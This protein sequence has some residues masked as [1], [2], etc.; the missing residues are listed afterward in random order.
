M[1]AERGVP[2]LSR[3]AGLLAD[4]TRARFCLA[5]LDGRAW[6]AG[7]LARQAGVAASTTTEHL[8]AL[9]AGGLLEQVRQGRHRYV[10]L[11]SPEVAELVE[12]LAALAPGPEPV[13]RSLRARTR[14][15]RLAHARTCYDHLA[16]R[17]GVAVTEAMIGRGILADS[18]GLHLTPTGSAWVESV[19]LTVARGTRR[20][21]VRP[22]L[23]WTERR[24]HLAGTLGAAFCSHAL[25][26]GW[27]TR[28]ATPRAVE[29]TPPGLEAFGEL[30]GITAG[31][32]R[33]AGAETVPGTPV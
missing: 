26:A 17:L 18:Q 25:T 4:P 11:A 21:A 19:G 27:I 30:L 20:P 28:T 8:N 13:P 10:R 16:G 22:C 29:V 12:R 24:F 15:H 1:E 9:V 3:V 33:G 23:D 2:G 14:Q 31:D 7:E 6:T 32:L 5:L